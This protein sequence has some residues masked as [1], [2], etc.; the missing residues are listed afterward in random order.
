MSIPGIRIPGAPM[1]VPQMK[2]PREVRRAARRA[3]RRRDRGRDNGN[4]KPL[5]R[6]NVPAVFL[7]ASFLAAVASSMHPRNAESISS[8]F[9][10]LSRYERHEIRL[11]GRADVVEALPAE[12][13]AG[14][15]RV[16][17]AGQHR[18]A[19]ARLDLPFELGT[20]DRITLVLLRRERICEVATLQSVFHAVDLTIHP[21][22]PLPDDE[23]V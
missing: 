20:D 10:L 3:K 8:Y 23:I 12:L 7:D 22:P 9:D 4:A 15:E 11:K 14:I 18:R 5:R 16:H 19:A 21:A 2:V 17:V 6:A 13:T 1:G